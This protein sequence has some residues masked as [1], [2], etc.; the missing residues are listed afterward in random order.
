[1]EAILG[2]LLIF[3]LRLSD[4]TLGRLR[5][6]MTVRGRKLL[7]ATI[8]FVEVTIFIVATLAPVLAPQAQVQQSQC[9]FITRTLGRAT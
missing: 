1:M 6:L 3:C 8:C 4:V 9:C 7:A 2:G 5:I